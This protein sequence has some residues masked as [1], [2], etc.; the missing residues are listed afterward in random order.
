[1]YLPAEGKNKAFSVVAS[2]Y[3]CIFFLVVNLV[4]SPNVIWF[5]YPS[6]AVLWWPLS[7]IMCSAKKYKLFSVVAS[8][9]LIAFLALVNYIASPQYIWFYYPAYAAL[10]WPMSMFMLKKNK[11]RIKLYSI[12][13]TAATIAWLALI[14]ILN[15][16]E[17]LWFQ[18]TVF[19]F[20]WWPAV[21]LLGKKAASTWFAVIGAAVIIAYHS[22]IYYI[23]TPG[24]HPWHLYIILPAVWWPVCI[25]LKKHIHRIWFLLLSLMV[26]AAYYVALN[27]IIY[28]Q[29]FWSLYLLYPEIVAVISLYYANR[30]KPFI[31]S[32]WVTGVS[33]I[34]FTTANYI[35]SPNVI[36]AIYPIFAI[37]WW[38]LSVYF[39]KAKK[40]KES[41]SLKEA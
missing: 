12:A 40:M 27:I 14:N 26:F 1:M 5:I 28:P 22:A 38:P 18:Y 2:L 21:M 11:N 6:F 39:Y 36:W 31:Y 37:L 8:L 24:F 25:A 17:Y 3:T 19:Y 30:K 34:F 41:E 29:Y 13:M 4:S 16:P 10:W 9:F 35:S 32:V 23:M 15:T 33:M 7:Y 20:L